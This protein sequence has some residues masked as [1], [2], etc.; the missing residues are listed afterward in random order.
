MMSA[1]VSSTLHKKQPMVSLSGPSFAKEV[2]EERPTSFVAA[3][4]DKQLCLKVQDLFASDS[5]RVNASKDVVG[6]EVCGAVK[7]VLA[8]AAGIVE[9]LGLGHNAMAG[10]I[11]QGCREIRWL[12]KKMGARAETVAG[13]AGMGDIML[14]CY[15]DLSRNRSVGVELGKGQSIHQILGSMQQVAEGVSTA[16]VVVGLAVQ[17]KLNLPVLTAV[18]EV[19][20]GRLSPEEA[21]YEIMQLPQIDEH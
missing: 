9:G 11:A 14:T 16:S 12:A 15:G 3:S 6:V 7:N 19:L 5:I 13:L 1:I 4:R 20:E 8:I 17:Y 2:M 10:L 18:A 21:V